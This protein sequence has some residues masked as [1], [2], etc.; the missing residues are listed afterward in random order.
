MD[1]EQSLK[2]RKKNLDILTPYYS[3]LLVHLATTRDLSHIYLFLTLFPPTV[4]GTILPVFQAQSN[5]NIWPSSP[6]SSVNYFF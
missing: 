1:S 3:A 4:N 6:S 5:I 2:K